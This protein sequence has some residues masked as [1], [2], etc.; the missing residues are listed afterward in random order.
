MLNKFHVFLPAQY[1][2]T[3]ANISDLK[4]LENVIAKFDE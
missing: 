2:V 1:K 3:S 4:R